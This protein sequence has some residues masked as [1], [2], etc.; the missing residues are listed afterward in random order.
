[1][2]PSSSGKKILTEWTPQQAI[3]ASIDPDVPP[4]PAPGVSGWDGAAWMKVISK[5]VAKKI[6]VSGDDTYIATAPIGTAQA[7]AGWQAKKIAIFGANYTITWADGDAKF[8][9]VATDL[10]ALSYS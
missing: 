2:P 10:T 3:N 8:N 4:F 6:T 5:L 7:T 1:M 9:N